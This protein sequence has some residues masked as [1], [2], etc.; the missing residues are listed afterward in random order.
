MGLHKRNSL[1]NLVNIIAEKWM[2]IPRRQGARA[3]WARD[4]SA[5]QRMVRSWTSPTPIP[6]VAWSTIKERV[7]FQFANSEKWPKESKM[8]SQNGW[9]SMAMWNCQK[10]IFSALPSGYWTSC[11]KLGVS[12]M[13]FQGIWPSD[14]W[15]TR[16]FLSPLGVDDSNGRTDSRLAYL[17]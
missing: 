14:L 16:H 7:I 5:P 1:G 9:C 11:A 4:G 6:L 3:S 17:T 15:Y 13:H 2:V 8:Q 10:A 12:M